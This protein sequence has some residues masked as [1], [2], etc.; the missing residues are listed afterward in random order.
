MYDERLW[1]GVTRLT[2]P[3]GN[4]TAL[5]GTARQV[6]EALMAYRRV[7]VDTVLIRGFDPLDDVV[8]WGRELVPLL[9]E[10]AARTPVGEPARGRGCPDRMTAVTSMSLPAPARPGSG[11]PGW[12]P[13]RRS[14]PPWPHGPP[15]TTGTARSRRTASAWCT[16]PG[17][18]PPPWPGVTAAPAPG[19]PP[20]C[21][22][23]RALGR[24]TR[25]WRW[26]RP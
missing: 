11:R 21:G 1:Y 17:C 18:S 26:S 7:G 16:T 14:R 23:L 4:S 19:W 3:G 8:E 12:P 6:A 13:S 25:R 10:E 20:P 2:G 5:V 9:R 24:V 22:I 15:A